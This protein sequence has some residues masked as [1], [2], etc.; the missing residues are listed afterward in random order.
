MGTMLLAALALGLP[1]QDKPLGEISQ[2]EFYQEIR[3]LGYVLIE[4]EKSALLV[5]GSIRVHVG[6][7][8][9]A[10]LPD[11][12]L[13]VLNGVGRL[14]FDLPRSIPKR[15]FQDWCK[16][17]SVS[18]RVT[19]GSFLGGRVFVE[20]WI[21]SRETTRPELKRNIRELLDACAKVTKLV[22]TRGGKPATSIHSV[23]SAR[24]EPD[25]RLDWI[26]PQDLDFMREKLKWGR[27]TMP[28]GFR[29]WCTG[30]EP[31]GIPVWYSGGPQPHPGVF[32]TSSTRE[33][34]PSGWK[35][36]IE[37]PIEPDWA[38]V[39]IVK[40]DFVHI[41]K[42]HSFPGGLT[43]RELENHILDFA[44]KVKALDLF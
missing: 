25:F 12:S 18:E 43:A 8:F 10:K 1:T 16:A 39:F 29:F 44:R 28:G 27:K 11:G 38:T 13:Y 15:E 2:E 31:L 30:A 36:Y 14:E 35:R 9:G 17:Q 32:M 4:E 21:M 41:E 23:G 20:N 3:A 24:Y 40:K 37:N 7:T 26:D 5:E 33:P 34:K 42:R 6:T 19:T 22:E